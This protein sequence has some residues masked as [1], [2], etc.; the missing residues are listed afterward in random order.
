MVK[1]KAGFCLKKYQ[2]F[3][4]E[5]ALSTNKYPNFKAL[6]KAVLLPESYSVNLTL[7]QLSSFRSGFFKLILHFTPEPWQNPGK[8]ENHD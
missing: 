7:N 3:L 2:G 5:S 1:K 8:S 6:C 4:P